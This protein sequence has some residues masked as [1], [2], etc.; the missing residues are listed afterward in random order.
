MLKTYCYN[1]YTMLLWVHVR[2]N[3]G[4]HS[5]YGGILG[6][7][8]RNLEKQE[9]MSE[10]DSSNGLFYP[11][12]LALSFN[13]LWGRIVYYQQTDLVSLTNGLFTKLWSEDSKI[14]SLVSSRL[15]IETKRQNLTLREDTAP[16]YVRPSSL[17]PRS[18]SLE[19]RVDIP[20]VT[21]SKNFCFQK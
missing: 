13:S 8:E 2:Y 20:Y 17:W 6:T 15:S 10:S 12:K 1:Y 3:A 11:L 4:K 18:G 9:R 19:L 16:K 7:R 21:F 5:C 14:I